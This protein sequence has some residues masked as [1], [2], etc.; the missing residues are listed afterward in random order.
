MTLLIS[1]IAALISTILW[2]LKDSSNEMKIG[3][4]CLMYWGASLMWF[5]DAIFEYLELGAD[6]FA[7]TAA[8]MLNDAYLGIC[9][10]VLGMIIWVVMLLIKDPK[11][12]LKSAVVRKHN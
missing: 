5:V 2:Y 6:Y 3:T 7:Q 12:V 10:V 8:D 11:N 4:L 1:T 9:V